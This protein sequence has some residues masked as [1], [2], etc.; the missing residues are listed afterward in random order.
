MH[1]PFGTDLRPPP[2]PPKRRRTPFLV[3]TLIVSLLAGGAFAASIT[4]NGGTGIEFGQGSVDVSACDASLGTPVLSATFAAEGFVV[5][6]VTLPGVDGNACFGKW[7]RIGLWD[8]GEAGDTL[9]DYVLFKGIQVTNP[10]S[11]TA[12]LPPDLPEWTLTD[13]VGTGLVAG[14]NGAVCGAYYE[15]PPNSATNARLAANIPSGA[16]DHFTV[17]T[18]DTEPTAVVA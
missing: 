2:Q 7:I 13:T 17:E 9:L 11:P 3:A 12:T 4:L 1:T 6:S 5:S 10:G 14:C 8:H 16:V 15:A 18:F